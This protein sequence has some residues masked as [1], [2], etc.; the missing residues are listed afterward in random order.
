MSEQDAN[1][2]YAIRNSLVHAF[3]VPDADSLQRLGITASPSGVGRGSTWT[4]GMRTS[5]WSGRAM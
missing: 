5:S 3:S 1:L 2:F 4:G